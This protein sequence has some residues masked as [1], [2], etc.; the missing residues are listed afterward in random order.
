MSNV[1]AKNYIFADNFFSK[2]NR[3]NFSLG[4]DTDIILL[5]SLMYISTM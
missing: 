3:I 2:Q 1:N 4:A 5:I